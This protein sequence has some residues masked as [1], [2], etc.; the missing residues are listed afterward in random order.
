M[1]AYPYEKAFEKMAG[2]SVGGK[3]IVYTAHQFNPDI[4]LL[5]IAA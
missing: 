3:G 2:I 1:H 5:F 4:C